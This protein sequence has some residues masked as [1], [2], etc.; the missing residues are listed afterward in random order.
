VQNIILIGTTLFAAGD[1]VVASTD[2]GATFTPV[3]LAG[4]SVQCLV[5]NGSQ[6]LAGLGTGE[7]VYLSGDNGTTWKASN[8]G[9][10][11]Q[12]IYSL[13]ASDS[14][15][16]AG[17]FFGGIFQSS[18]NGGSWTSAL[19]R[20]PGQP[21]VF[22]PPFSF[23]AS[24]DNIIA[25][26]LMGGQ[27]IV[28]S[29]DQGQTWT[30]TGL[31]DDNG[32]LALSAT[33][34]DVYAGAGS[35]K[36]YIS[37]N[38]GVDW[39]YKGST[40]LQIFSLFAEGNKVYAGSSGGGVMVS[41][42][43]GVNW[44]TSNNGLTNLYVYALTK[45]GTTLYA[46]TSVGIFISYNGGSSWALAN[47]GVGGSI[48]SLA[49][50]KGI[51]VACADFGIYTSTNN[52]LS[53]RAWGTDLQGRI[54]R[55]VAFNKDFV[56]AGTDNSVYKKQ[57][58]YAEQFSPVLGKVGTTVTILGEFFSLTPSE[59][60]VQFNG[61]PASVLSS[62]STSLTVTVPTSA[63]TGKISVTIG[64]LTSAFSN[65]FTVVPDITSFT[66]DS[67]P[68]GTTVT[69]T[70]TTFSTTPSENLVQFN[71]TSAVV[72]SSTAT[73]IV[74]TVPNGAKVGSGIISVAVSGQN[75]TSANTF[76]INPP[77]PVIT[78]SD[79]NT[80]SS[81]ALT[82]N[83]WFRNGV[84][85]ANATGTTMT[86]SE[87][88]TYTVQVTVDACKSVMSNEFVAVVTGDSRMFVRDRKIEVY[89]S[90]SS[91]S[92]N[93]NLE[94]L[95][96][97]QAASINIFDMLG[98]LIGELRSEGGTIVGLDVTTYATGMYIIN[99]TQSG[100]LYHGRFIKQ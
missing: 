3:W 56:F 65:N 9:L 94:N 86:I 44:T 68:A 20:L 82:G 42:D 48:N 37:H 73:S 81:S 15:L 13:H 12:Q 35:G 1:G 76:C 90:P 30:S 17:S 38:N 57:L 84:S 19:A 36:V 69:I 98:H 59:N 51:V 18:D 26:I 70:G 34:S 29:H 6:I 89:P 5:V 49:A 40:N 92:V 99:V 33:G 75:A 22:L 25:A 95:S 10:T 39:T 16:L 53:W 4:K 7:G 64:N 63:T 87:V 85:M 79:V 50:Y 93:I 91:G 2:N 78:F 11:D 45:N 77:K 97:G 52:G 96:D 61:V 80:L 71:G 72:T 14:H 8:Q 55:S 28:I 23:C 46:G 32:M 54:V 27:G 66:P 31:V 60:V 100:A 41:E 24:G 74:T 21:Y 58:L 83:Q 88:G 43:G 62:T 67:G 47:G